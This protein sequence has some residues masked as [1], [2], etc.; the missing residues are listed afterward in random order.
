[1]TLYRISLLPG[2]DPQILSKQTQGFIEAPTKP[3]AIAQF[4]KSPANKWIDLPVDRIVAEAKSEVKSWEVEQE[5]FPML[6]KSA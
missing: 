3:K 1:M 4:I 5:L 2:F 6:P